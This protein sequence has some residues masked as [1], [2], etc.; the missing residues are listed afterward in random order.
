MQTL[1]ERSK[2]LETF[3]PQGMRLNSV[4]YID[5]NFSSTI[6]ISLDGEIES[7]KLDVYGLK[8]VSSELFCINFIPFFTLKIVED[9]PLL[10]QVNSVLVYLEID[11]FYK[12]ELSL[13]AKF[14]ELIRQS[15]RGWDGFYELFLFSRLR[16]ETDKLI[17]QVPIEFY[18]IA[19]SFCKSNQIPICNKG[20]EENVNVR[21]SKLLIFTNEFLVKDEEFVNQHYLIGEK[22][23]IGEKF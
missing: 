10:R 15:Y 7:Y 13:Q 2:D 8:K 3:L 12:L 18:H 9:H 4:S 19:E 1:L 21:K 6:E 16:K 11:G 22:I 23:R 17:G 14:K 5:N 20:M